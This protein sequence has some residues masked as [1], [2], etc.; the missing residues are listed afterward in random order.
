MEYQSIASDKTPSE[1]SEESFE[2][3]ISTKKSDSIDSCEFGIEEALLAGTKI[4]KRKKQSAQTLHSVLESVIEMVE[5]ADRQQSINIS[6]TGSILAM[7][8]SQLIT[9]DELNIEKI[10]EILQE[11]HNNKKIFNDLNQLKVYLSDKLGIDNNIQG[12]RDSVKEKS[13]EEPVEIPSTIT[14]SNNETSKI[15]GEKNDSVEFVAD[16]TMEEMQPMPQI[17]DKFMECAIE[18]DEKVGGAAVPEK[19]ILGLMDTPSEHSIEPSPIIPTP[20]VTPPSPTYVSSGI[21]PSIIRSQIIDSTT[22]SVTSSLSELATAP[23][24]YKCCMPALPGIGKSV[25]K[26]AMQNFLTFLKARSKDENGMILPRIFKELKCPNMV[27][28]YEA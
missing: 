28:C 7:I 10:I 4:P 13:I 24:S 15:E 19:M 5:V 27:D 17:E 26:E 11:A 9:N 20:P 3:D 14:I 16:T 8:Q 18:I 21:D 12:S 23:P 6:D 2:F 22:S 25:S 1:S